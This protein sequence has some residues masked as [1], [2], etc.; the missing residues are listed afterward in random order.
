MSRFKIKID[1]S[2]ED[3]QPHKVTITITHDVV[4]GFVELLKETFEIEMLTAKRTSNA[5]EHKIVMQINDRGKITRLRQAAFK[6]YFD[7]EKQAN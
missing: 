5:K 4:D 3:N 6:T 7:I 2:I 1:E